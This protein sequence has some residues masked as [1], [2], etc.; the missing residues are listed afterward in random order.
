MTALVGFVGTKLFL[1]RYWLAGIL[2]YKFFFQ[3]IKMISHSDFSI[4][5]LEKFVWLFY[6][7]FGK[8]SL[9][10][11][12]FS[13]MILLLANMCI[14]SCPPPPSTIKRTTA[15]EMPSVREAILK[16]SI[17]IL[18]P[19]KLWAKRNA[20]LPSFPTLA[21][22]LF[23]AF[24]HC[25]HRCRAVLLLLLLHMSY[26]IAFCENAILKKFSVSSHLSNQ[27]TIQA[28]QNFRFVII[29]FVGKWM[30]G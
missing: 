27:P 4:I 13:N 16:N 29:T 15:I 24:I 22:P 6:V 30:S 5:I 1:R 23:R 11:V 14:L 2:V 9:H 10:L 28:K 12:Q 21:C 25:C 3:L 20:G 18:N 26:D 17:F 19:L 7:R 8:F